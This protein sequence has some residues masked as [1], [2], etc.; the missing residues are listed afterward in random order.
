MPIDLLALLDAAA[1]GTPP[2][3][4]G[5]VTVLT[6]PPGPVHAVLGFTGHH[7]I[8][9][10]VDDVTVSHRLDPDDLGAAMNASFLLFLAGWLGASPGSLDVVLV[11]TGPE[12]RGTPLQLWRRADLAEH[13]RIRR[14]ARY[15]S[16]LAV[17]A[18]TPPEVP[19]GGVVM[20]GRGLATRWETSFEVEPAQRGRGLG[21]RLAAAA[22]TLVPADQPLWA[23]VAPGNA[24]SLRA[25]L[26]A[27][28]RPVGSEVLFPSP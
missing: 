13:P 12:P 19:P 24:A 21:R 23:Q 1:R 20:V 14:A 16:D 15:R 26:A 9:A 2:P 17:Y 7:V 10:E 27:G 6:K 11:H 4:D 5:G 8:A 28:Y 18:D 25:V 3:A 22:R